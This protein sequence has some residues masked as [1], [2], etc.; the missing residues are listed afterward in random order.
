[1]CSGGQMQNNPQAESLNWNQMSDGSCNP[2][3]PQVWEKERRK[4]TKKV[5]GECCTRRKQITL[6]SVILRCRCAFRSSPSKRAYLSLWFT[7]L[8]TCEAVVWNHIHSIAIAFAQ[9][10]PLTATA[11]PGS[12]SIPN[13]L[14]LPRNNRI[15]SQS[16]MR[17]SCGWERPPSAQVTSVLHPQMLQ[18]WTSLKVGKCT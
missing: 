8:Y 16:S 11:P 10:L 4:V 1:M 3:I 7:G 2:R 5:R 9:M 13:I 12:A 14:L 15:K 6:S 18:G 17:N